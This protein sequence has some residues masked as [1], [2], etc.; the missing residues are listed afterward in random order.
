[1]ETP[2]IVDSADTSG[3]VPESLGR[4]PSF[5][6]GHVVTNIVEFAACTAICLIVR[7]PSSTDLATKSLIESLN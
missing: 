7:A 5:D 4:L 3:F 1:M 6:A 2:V